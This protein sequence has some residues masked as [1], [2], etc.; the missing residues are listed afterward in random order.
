MPTA[1]FTKHYIHTCDS[2]LSHPSN[3]VMPNRAVALVVLVLRTSDLNTAMTVPVQNDF[4]FSSLVPSPAILYD[5]LCSRYR[6][7]HRLGERHRGKWRRRP[8]W[9]LRSAGYCAAARGGSSPPAHVAGT[10]KRP[11]PGTPEPGRV[12]YLPV[13]PLRLF[14]AGLPAAPSGTGR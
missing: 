9:R 2:L 12:S 1:P 7:E 11:G 3:E 13:G 8:L 5:C 10:R 4:F 6:C 14:E